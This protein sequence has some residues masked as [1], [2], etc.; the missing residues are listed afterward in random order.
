MRWGDL[1]R[2]WGVGMRAGCSGLVFRTSICRAKVRRREE[3]LVLGRATVLLCMFWVSWGSLGNLRGKH[4]GFRSKDP[5][6]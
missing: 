3:V 4:F 1:G 2:T 5:Y 6:S